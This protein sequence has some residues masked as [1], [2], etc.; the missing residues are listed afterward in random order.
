VSKVQRELL[1]DWLMMAAAPLLFIS[2]FLPWSHQIS[3]GLA[4]RYAHS[5]ALPGIPRDPTAWQVYSIVDVLLALLVVALIL[6]ALFGLGSGRLAVA[7]GL[8]LALVFTIHAMAVPPTNGVYLPSLPGIA[9]NHPQSGAGEVLA[10]I[11]L[12]A[13]TAGVL[14]SLTVE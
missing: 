13:G 9:S 8:L 4:A 10:A 1:S 14:L 2:L 12:V 3:A 6:V 11:A 5:P 7:G